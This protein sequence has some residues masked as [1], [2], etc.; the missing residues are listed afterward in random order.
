VR[1]RSPPPSPPLLFRSPPLVP[2]GLLERSITFRSDGDRETRVDVRR[3]LSMKQS[4]V[5]AVEYT[6]TPGGPVKGMANLTSKEMAR[7]NLRRPAAGELWCI[8]K[9]VMQPH[10]WIHQ[11][12]FSDPLFLRYAEDGSFVIRHTPIS[13]RSHFRGPKLWPRLITPNLHPLF[14]DSERSPSVTLPVG[15]PP[16]KW[17]CLN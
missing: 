16:S 10:N 15:G 17:R 6:V 7:A 11:L 1:V 5:G 8:K 9:G 14:S 13:G 3:L 12:I 2:A 4:H